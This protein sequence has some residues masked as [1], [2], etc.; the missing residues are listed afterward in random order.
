MLAAV[1]LFE[2]T[3]KL[4]VHRETSSCQIFPHILLARISFTKTGPQ[5]A[6]LQAMLELK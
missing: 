2:A 4:K 5:G 1:N 6:S 3:L